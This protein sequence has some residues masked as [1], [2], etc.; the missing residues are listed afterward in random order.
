MI[1]LIRQA[2]PE[3]DLLAITLKTVDI[4]TCMTMNRYVY[5]LKLVFI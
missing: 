5:A 1:M 4:D 2:L 3:I